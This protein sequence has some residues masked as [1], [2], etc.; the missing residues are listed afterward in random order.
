MMG[1]FSGLYFAAYAFCLSLVAVVSHVAMRKRR[2][3]EGTSINKKF[4]IMMYGAS[5]A[6]WSSASIFTVIR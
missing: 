3:N 2:S 1:E 5:T 4:L 6:F